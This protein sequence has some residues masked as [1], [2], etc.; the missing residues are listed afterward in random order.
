MHMPASILASSPS[1]VVLA[2]GRTSE[3]TRRLIG[4]VVAICSAGILALAAYLQPSDTG[5][6]THAQLTRVQCGW[7]VLMDTPCPTCGMTTAF[8]HAADGHLLAALAAQPLGALLAVATAMALLIGVYVAATGS[9]VAAM[10]GRLWGPRAAWALG[11]LVV[12]AWTYK[13]IIY[14]GLLE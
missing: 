4:T 1:A 7:I 12:S 5:L 10:F 8:A 6:G 11:G 14:K 2:S 3:T 13:I 9:R